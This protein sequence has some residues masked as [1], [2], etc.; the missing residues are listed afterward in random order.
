V[1]IYRKRGGKEGGE[2]VKRED[3]K[4]RCEGGELLGESIWEKGWMGIET[5]GDR[6]WIY[7][8]R[9]LQQERSSSPVEPGSQ[10][11]SGSC[12]CPQTHRWVIHHPS[13]HWWNLEAVSTLATTSLSKSACSLLGQFWWPKGN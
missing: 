9:Y 10:E 2:G 13:I 8:R 4:L 11:G 3:G 7:R 5:E 1:C 6:L 12:P